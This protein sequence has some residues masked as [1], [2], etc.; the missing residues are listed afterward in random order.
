[1]PLLSIGI[2]ISFLLID[3]ESM[4]D[5]TLYKRE[6]SVIASSSILDNPHSAAKITILDGPDG[7]GKTTY[8]NELKKRFE[9]TGLELRTLRFPDN[10][11]DAHIR[12]V[13]M[14]EDIAQNPSAQ[15]FLFFADMLLAFER[16]IQPYIH[17]Q[18]VRFVLDRFLP[19]TM[20]YQHIDLDFIN[21]TF[22]LLYPE[23]VKTFRYA[24]YIYLMPN[25]LDELKERI[26]SKQGVEKNHFD[27]TTTLVMKNQVID[28]WNIISSHKE[29]G[30]LGSY[31]AEIIFN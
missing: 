4:T 7:T 25:S 19:S 1:M 30:I 26:A 24:H 18:N 12:D 8:I 11:G 14:S 5:I 16:D 6:S 22:G 13:I 27:P 9:E 21:S 2:Y 17:N 23:F 28:Y 10:R 20:V 31:S 3:R 15:M 29:K